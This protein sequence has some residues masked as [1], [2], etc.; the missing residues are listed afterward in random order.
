MAHVDGGALGD[1]Q[2]A[3]RANSCID[4]AVDLDTGLDAEEAGLKA[5]GSEALGV[6][7]EVVDSGGELRVMPHGLDM[8]HLGKDG[9]KGMISI[10]ADLIAERFLIVMPTTSRLKR[11]IIIGICATELLGTHPKA[12]D[13]LPDTPRKRALYVPDKMKMIRHQSVM[14]HLE[15]RRLVSVR[16]KVEISTRA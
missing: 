9:V 4:A 5:L 12:R 2:E 10:L 11:R 3:R 8:R 6:H 7:V 1:V 14:K 15:I 13:D 16:P